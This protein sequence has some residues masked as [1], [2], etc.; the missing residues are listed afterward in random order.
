MGKKDI[1]AAIDIGSSKVVAL[2]AIV[3]DRELISWG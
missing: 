1:I 3:E 2:I